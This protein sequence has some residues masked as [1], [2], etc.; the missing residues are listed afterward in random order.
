MGTAASVAAPGAD[1]D[2]EAALAGA[3]A[4]LDGVLANLATLVVENKAVHAMLERLQ[5][6]DVRKAVAGL[7]LIDNAAVHELRADLAVAVLGALRQSTHGGADHL[8]YEMPEG[9]LREFV[10]ICDQP[11]VAQFVDRAE[12]DEA[13]RVLL[14]SPDNPAAIAALRRAADAIA[15]AL[16]R[17]VT[18]RLS[19][20]LVA[21]TVRDVVE[22]GTGDE[23]FRGVYEAVWSGPMAGDTAGGEDYRSAVRAMVFPA[24][25]AMQQAADAVQLL[26]QGARVKPRFDSIMEGIVEGLKDVRLSIP[27]V[28]GRVGGWAHLVVVVLV[29]PGQVDDPSLTPSMYA[30][31]HSYPTVHA[32][33]RP[34]P[35]PPPQVAQGH[36][37]H[38][39]EGRTQRARPRRLPR[40]IRRGPRHGRVPDALCRCRGAPPARRLQRRRV[41]A[42]QGALLRRAEPGRLARLHGVPGR[43]GRLR[44]ACLR[45]ADHALADAHGAQR[46]A[47]PR[48]VQQGAERPGD[49]GDAGGGGRLPVLPPAVDR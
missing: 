24:A 44:A 14:A 7:S 35:R 1:V 31:M 23:N 34:A 47:G 29:A 41:G 39:R 11:S 3:I 37:S 12:L 25:G 28:S 49:P 6:N 40:R 32:P 13:Q 16:R 15:P 10:P 38:P 5:D 45:A 26:Q 30:L 48:G 18:D 2:A 36:R 42:L 22:A 19:E 4:Q 9:P 43:Q 17:A 46:A 27:T 33:P 20:A 21:K 8:D